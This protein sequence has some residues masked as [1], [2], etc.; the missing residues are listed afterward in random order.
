MIPFFAAFAY[1]SLRSFQQ[2]NVVYH[3][4]WAILPVSIA[5]AFCDFFLIGY[6][7]MATI[8]AIDFWGKFWLISQIGIGGG[9]GSIISTI[10]HRRIRGRNKTNVDT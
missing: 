2:L 6:I 1:V 7:A 5:M 4:L 9:L 8:E 10:L 3:K